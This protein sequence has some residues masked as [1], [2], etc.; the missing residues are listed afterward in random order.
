M[1][2]M[3]LAPGFEEVE[4]L[5]PLDLLRR[6]NLA[7]KTVAIGDKRTVV[8]SH[9]IPVTADITELEW[10][11]EPDAATPEAVI[12]PGG[13]PGTTHLSHDRAVEKDRQADHCVGCKQCNHHCPQ[14]IDIPKE[15]RR[16]DK[17]IEDLKQGR[18][19]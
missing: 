12:L 18:E 15:I 1:I 13:M 19:F 4:A 8:G 3:F 7:V 2:Y 11:K 14:R 10:Y 17:Y 5:F 16:I 9:G 6:A